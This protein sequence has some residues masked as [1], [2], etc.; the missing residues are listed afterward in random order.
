MQDSL[1]QSLDEVLEAEKV[2]TRAH[3]ELDIATIERMLAHEYI[4]VCDTGR[5]IYREEA[6]ASYRSGQRRWEIAQSDELEVHLYGETAVV[7]GRWTGR[8]ENHGQRFDYTAWFSCVFVRREK[9]WQIVLDHSTP[10]A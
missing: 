5:V 4:L 6:L 1:S 9:G 3:L 2:W 7:I 10:L 8:G